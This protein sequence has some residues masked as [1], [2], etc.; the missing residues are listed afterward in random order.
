MAFAALMVRRSGAPGPK[1]TRDTEPCLS[2]M[3]LDANACCNAWLPFLAVM[4]RKPCNGWVGKGST[5]AISSS[6]PR[7]FR[8]QVATMAAS[9]LPSFTCWTLP[10]IQPRIPLIVRSGRNSFKPFLRSGLLVPM[11]LPAGSSA[12][13][14]WSLLTS[15]SVVS[16]AGKRAMTSMSS[17]R[18]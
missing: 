5:S 4:A 13:F 7:R 18:G 12:S 9:Y 14:L 8:A 15:E 16:K 17:G 2:R 6:M 1:P 11:I 10:S 3:L